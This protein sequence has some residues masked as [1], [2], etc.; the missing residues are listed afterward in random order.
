MR[1]VQSFTPTTYQQDL[2]L[3]LTLTE[4]SVNSILQ[5]YD[6]VVLYTTPTVAELVKKR[7]IKYTEINT[8]LFKEDDLEIANY[9]I[10]KI[11]CYL[12]QKVPFL[13]IDYDVILLSRFTVDKDFTVS[14]YDFDLINNVVMLSQLDS[15]NNYYAQDLKKIHT[16]LPDSIQQMAD[17]RLLPNFSIFGVN[18]LTLCKGIFKDILKFYNE[19]RETFEKLDHSPSMLEQFLFMTYLRHSLN[20]QIDIETVIGTLMQHPVEPEDYINGKRQYAKF[21]HLQGVNKTS[22]FVNQLVTYLNGI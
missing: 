13:H 10:P 6:E 1:V 3:Y 8:E 17:F 20:W 22:E 16:Q 4:A 5:F 19:N 12:E 2:D 11:Q 7:G 18:N 21:L 15:L 14:Y 9:A